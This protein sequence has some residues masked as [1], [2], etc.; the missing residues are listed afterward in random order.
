VFLVSEP[1]RY[2]EAPR[3]PDGE[4]L[5]LGALVGTPGEPVELEVGP[6]RGW[7]AI[8]RLQAREDVRL[9][10]LEIK[11][12]WASL[13]DQRLQRRGLGTRGR[14]FCAD[15]RL[16]LPRLRPASVSVAYVH[17]PDPWWK[18]RHNKRL[19]IT[20]AFVAELA[21][22]LTPGGEVFVQTDVHERAL[23]Y[24][25]TFAANAE[26]V[27][28]PAGDPEAAPYQAR[29]PRERRARRDGLPI[30][31]LRYSRC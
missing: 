15:A 2:L 16:V 5:D 26:F 18:K 25:S 9:V 28:L 31:R 6:G 1:R 23:A 7:F 17:F 24:E 22:V 10:G 14:V 19:L 12:K 3:L 29:S 20:P 4:G 13:V 8:E 27:P 21:R 11:R 30:F